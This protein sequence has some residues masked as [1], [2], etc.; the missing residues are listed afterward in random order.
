MDGL[1]EISNNIDN[2]I[3]D[4]L[5]EINN[6]EI[7]FYQRVYTHGRNF[8][9]IGFFAILLASLLT[10]EMVLSL[11]VGLFFMLIILVSIVKWNIYYIKY[12]KMDHKYVDLKVYK[13]NSI[14]IEGLFPL[15]DFSLKI[16]RASVSKR[17]VSYKLLVSNGQIQF[18]QY[19]IH[20][21][22]KVQFDKIIA[23]S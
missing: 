23:L 7:S 16:E 15:S 17:G 5:L 14:I 11:I 13:Y 3:K 2:L 20:G 4:C 8:F 12:I 18:S 21:W 19:E 6:N 22:N 9:I 1:S 10:G